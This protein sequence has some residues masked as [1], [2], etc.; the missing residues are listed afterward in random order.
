MTAAIH[1]IT[2]PIYVNT[3]KGEGDAL[4]LLDYG[5]NINTVWV[6]HIHEDSTVIHVDSSDVR[7]MGNLMYGLHHPE[8]PI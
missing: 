8:R 1:Q 6:V 7:I 3:P 2:P 5:V 4:F